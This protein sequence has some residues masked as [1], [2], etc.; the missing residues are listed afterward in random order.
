MAIKVKRDLLNYSRWK[1]ETPK[2]ILDKVKNFGG[3]KAVFQNGIPQDINRVRNY[4]N[5]LPKKLTYLGTGNSIGPYIFFPNGMKLKQNGGVFD[6]IGRMSLTG[7]YYKDDQT[8]A[9]Y[10]FQYTTGGTGFH[11]KGGGTS[12]YGAVKEQAIPQ[13]LQPIFKLIHPDGTGGSSEVIVKNFQ[14]GVWKG[15][16]STFGKKG[17]S[18][19]LIGNKIVSRIV[20]DKE[21][22]GSYNFS[23]AFVQSNRDHTIRDVIPHQKKKKP[24]IDPPNQ[25]LPLADTSRKFPEYDRGKRPI[26]EIGPSDLPPLKRS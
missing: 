26:K 25:H 4:F 7:D 11:Q 24:Y 14:R 21:L 18:V 17:I 13:R 1:D 12:W 22:Q 10:W 5:V 6:L 8:P 23:D 3:W 16:K 2:F 15:G 9:R 20:T 19:P